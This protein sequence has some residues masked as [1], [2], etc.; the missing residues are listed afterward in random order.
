MH[1]VVVDIVADVV[2][3]V[4]LSVGATALALVGMLSEQAGVTS[5]ATGN[6]AL[7]LWYLYMG[8]LALFVGLYLLGYQQVAPRVSALLAA[9]D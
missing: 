5:L 2:A 7:G 9:T 1:E 8:G 4:L 6:L 3:V